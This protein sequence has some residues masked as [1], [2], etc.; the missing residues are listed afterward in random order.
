LIA[1]EMPFIMIKVRSIREKYF[2][3]LL[4]ILVFLLT[5]QLEL[6]TKPV[7]SWMK[8]SKVNTETQIIYIMI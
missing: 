2:M 6:D 1:R 3:Y 5:M 8:T 4:I 7:F